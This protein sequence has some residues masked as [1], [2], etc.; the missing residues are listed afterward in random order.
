MFQAAVVVRGRI[1][2]PGPQARPP[3]PRPRPAPPAVLHMPTRSLPRSPK[4]PNERRLL[5]KQGVEREHGRREDAPA[6]A[7]AAAL[8]LGDGAARRDLACIEAAAKLDE[9]ARLL[10]RRPLLVHLRAVDAELLAAVDGVVHDALRERG[11]PAEAELLLEVFLLGC[12]RVEL[13]R[14]R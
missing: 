11:L 8:L 14:L 1:P 5:A 9:V 12:G 3:R 2:A 13:G 4:R 6:A 10:G 7:A